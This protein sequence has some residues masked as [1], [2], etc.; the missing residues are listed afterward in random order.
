VDVVHHDREGC[1]IERHVVA[2]RP[3]GTNPN[4]PLISPSDEIDISYVA[5]IR[6]G[7]L[8]IAGVQSVIQNPW[9]IVT[10]DDPKDQSFL[11]IESR[12]HLG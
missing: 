10:V 12:C 5:I 6:V 1:E 9:K 7:D 8:S 2:Q 11:G 3:S 4:F